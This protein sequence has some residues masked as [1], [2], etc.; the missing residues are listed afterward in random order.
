MAMTS[1]PLYVYGDWNRYKDTFRRAKQRDPQLAEV[2]LQPTEAVPGCG[3]LLSFGEH[4]PFVAEYALVRKSPEALEKEGLASHLLAWYLGR[5]QD[6][7]TVSYAG[8]LT[9]M[10]GR[11]VRE[12]A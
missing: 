1:K 5:V 8:A 3:R 10:F 4:P 9:R 7:R 12:V 2:L 11:E 6:S